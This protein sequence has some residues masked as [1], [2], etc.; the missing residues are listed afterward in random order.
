MWGDQAINDDNTMNEYLGN[1]PERAIKNVKDVITAYRYHQI[2]KIQNNLVAQSNRVRDMFDT[3]D[4]AILAKNPSY[5]KLN[6]GPLWA[7]WMRGRADRAR[8]RAETYTKQ[9]VN[10]LKTGYGTE[11]QR[12]TAD[13]DR[14][15]LLSKID[16]LDTE[17]TNV[18]NG[19]WPNPL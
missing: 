5:Q 18:I 10:A 3:M 14:K 16:A 19:G 4:T 6:L 7:S 2:Q 1:T 12:E 17:V 9:W 15:I 13:A 8:T 11:S